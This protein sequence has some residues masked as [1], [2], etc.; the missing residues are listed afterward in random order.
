M[1]VQTI[2]VGVVAGVQT[3]AAIP[4]SARGRPAPIC[5]EDGIFPEAAAP[6]LRKYAGNHCLFCSDL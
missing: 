2:D 3:L 5:F 4:N 1:D 6:V